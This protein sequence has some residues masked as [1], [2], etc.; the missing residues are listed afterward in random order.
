[1]LISFMLLFSVLLRPSWATALGTMYFCQR[2]NLGQLLE[3]TTL[4]PFLVQNLCTS[5][6]KDPQVASLFLRFM[7]LMSP[8]VSQQIWIVQRLSWVS[9]LQGLVSWPP[10]SESFGFTGGSMGQP[11]GVSANWI[12]HS[13]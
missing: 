11:A 8:E 1:M 7:F 5:S 13:K 10:K 4:W 12:G 9:W 3:D 6:G 2:W